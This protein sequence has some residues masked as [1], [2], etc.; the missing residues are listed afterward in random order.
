MGIWNNLFAQNN[1]TKLIVYTNYEKNYLIKHPENW[2][3]QQN[4]DGVISIESENIKGGIYISA[5]NNITFPD[6]NMNSFILQSN[7]LPAEF[8]QNI[9]NGE[10]NGIKSWYLSYTDQKKKL[11][12]MS[13]YKRKGENLWFFSTEIDPELWKKGW[14]EIIIEIITSIE[15]K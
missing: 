2:K 14:K 10:E 5:Y 1:K 11:T 12:C 7:H 9:L 8:E 4:S 13:I 6:E 15:L 3:I